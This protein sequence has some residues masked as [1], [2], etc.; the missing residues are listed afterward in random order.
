[1]GP[2]SKN[3]SNSSESWKSDPRVGSGNL[4]HNISNQESWPTR[5]GGTRPTTSTGS[6]ESSGT[7]CGCGWPSRSR[8]STPASAPAS[9]DQLYKIGLPGKSILGDYFQENMTS[10]R[11]FL[12]PRISF[13]GRPILY[14]CPREQMYIEKSIGTG[15]GKNTP[16]IWTTP[17]V[18]VRNIQCDTLRTLIR[19]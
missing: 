5:W 18:K 3:G 7:C 15:P 1:M 11:P 17:W 19:T 2:I 13:P 10:R 16:T 4:N 6:A 9:R 12:L 14:N 8:P